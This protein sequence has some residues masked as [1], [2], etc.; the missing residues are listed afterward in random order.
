ME[1]IFRYRFAFSAKLQSRTNCRLSAVLGFSF[2]LKVPTARNLPRRNREETGQDY[3]DHDR[4]YTTFPPTAVPH[5]AFFRTE[6]HCNRVFP[7]V[8]RSLFVELSKLGRLHPGLAHLFLRGANASQRDATS[9]E[10]SSAETRPSVSCFSAAYSEGLVTTV[11]S[12]DPLASAA[13]RSGLPPPIGSI[14][15]SLLGSNPLRLRAA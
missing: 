5:A 4:A 7:K 11:A 15:R 3:T 10:S 6:R 8:M 12:T 1:M 2:N 9:L 13:K 14:V